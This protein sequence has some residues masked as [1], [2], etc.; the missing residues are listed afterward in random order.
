MDC[1][2]FVSNLLS[3]IL[4]Y[5]EYSPTVEYNEIEIPTLVGKN[6]E[7]AVDE[8]KTLNLKYEIIG[9][10]KTVISQTPGAQNIASVKNLKIVL[11]TDEITNIVSI[12]SFVGLPLS[13]AVLLAINSGLNISIGD[14][15]SGTVVY[16]SLPLGAL[17]ARGTVIEL[18]TMVLDFED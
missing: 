14:T 8:L 4:P 13:D 7:K 17:V 1:K 6:V 3:A 11:Y 12:P 16:Q 5:L 10:G 9:D 15:A 18:K 2:T